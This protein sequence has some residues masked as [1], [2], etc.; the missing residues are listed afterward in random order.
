[1]LFDHEKFVISPVRVVLIVGLI[2]ALLIGGYWLEHHVAQIEGWIQGLGYWAGVAFILLFLA[3]TPLLFS[4]DALCLIAGAVFSLSAAFAYV[5]IAT[6]LA[7]ALIFFIGRWM[8]CEQI[9]TLVA[10]NE[11]L[12][13]IDRLLQHG[14]FKILFLLRLL[15]IPFAPLSYAMSVSKTRFVPY[16]LA[17]TG[18]FF[19]HLIITY[20]GYTAAHFS[21]QM[22]QGGQAAGPSTAMLAGGFVFCIAVVFLILRVARAELAQMSEFSG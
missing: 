21:K 11:R 18:I 4:V 14:G 5:L 13:S 6:M 17:T 9:Q 12:R 7:S 20:F 3:L 19:Y 16:W 10:K 1:M 8:A 22:V 15:P 2:V